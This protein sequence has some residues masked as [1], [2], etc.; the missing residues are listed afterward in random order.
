MISALGDSE[1]A[2]AVEALDQDS[3]DVL[4]KYLYRFM[5]NSSSCGTCLK[6]HALVAEKAGAGSII[7]VL[8]DRKQV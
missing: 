6:L 3:C 2:A 7:R 5:G 1:L 8:T 4:M